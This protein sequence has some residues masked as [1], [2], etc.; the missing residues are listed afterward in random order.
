M[1][2]ITHGEENLKQVITINMAWERLCQ[3]NN[4]G[5]TIANYFYTPQKIP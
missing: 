5:W 3:L 1:Y 2:T 4:F